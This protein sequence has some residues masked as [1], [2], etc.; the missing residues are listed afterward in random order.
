MIRKTI[1]MPDDMGAWIE[2][3]IKSGQYNN[4]SEYF[5]DLVRRD[6]ERQQAE[7]KLLRLLEEAEASG[8]SDMTPQE[9]WDQAE[10]R[11]LKKNG[12]I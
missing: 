7:A 4:D 1:S 2:G 10:R 3:R 12:E 6:R 8:V 5:R 9:I 11:Y